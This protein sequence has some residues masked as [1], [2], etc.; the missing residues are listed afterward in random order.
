MKKIDLGTLHSLVS[1]IVPACISYAEQNDEK[2]LYI[3][4]VDFKAYEVLLNEMKSI[5]EEYG[6]EGLYEYLENIGVG[7][8][9][10]ATF[11][12]IASLIKSLDSE[13]LIVGGGL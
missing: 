3:V 5:A 10:N 2:E 6:S 7:V 13:K 12:S 4:Y 11:W 1:I 8:I 9:S